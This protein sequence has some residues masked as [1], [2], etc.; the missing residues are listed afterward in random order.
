MAYDVPLYKAL[1]RY[2]QRKRVCFHMPG[3][4]RGNGIP[5][6]FKKDILSMDLTELNDTDN[7]HKP[8]GPI[9]KAQHL[10]AKAFGAEK[11]FFLVNGATCGIEA[12]ITA[13]CDPG[14][15]LIIDR[16]CH[17][18]VISALILTGVIPKYI[19]PEYIEELGICGGIHLKELERMLV[20]NPKAKGVLI[21]S[22]NYYGLCSDIKAIAE[23]V[24]LHNKLLLVDEAHGTH[25]YFSSR[26]P[27]GAL[28]SGADL[29]VHGAHKTLPALTQ[30]GF[31]HVKSE[32]VDIRR[33][34]NSLKLF[35]TSSPSFLLLAYLDISRGIMQRV[36][37]TKF[38][39]ILRLTDTIRDKING[40]KGLYCFGTDLKGKHGVCDIDLTR[41]VVN[42]KNAGITGYAASEMLRNDYN[43]EVEMS[44][45]SN[46]IC[47]ITVSDDENSLK[48]LSKALIKLNERINKIKGFTN[49]YKKAF[50]PI[51]SISPREAFFSKTNLQE[52]DNSVGKVCAE[53]VTVFPPGVP[54]LCPGEVISQEIVEYI[55]EIKKHKGTEH[56]GTVLLCRED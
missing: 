33:L 25:F 53:T 5:K 7:L 8:E 20:D 41:L 36:G 39:K 52:L 3:H 30:S 6:R 46:I 45:I 9:L 56:E 38:N 31:L 34:E 11:S 47:I 15:I 51:Y 10:A 18:S 32:R 24:H 17:G 43:I 35:Q 28:A 49:P 19:Y 42:F 50:K 29:C 16:N 13:V 48:K 2:V 21:T 23:L 55:K 54:I 14:D 40:C 4:K 22:P 12:M 26:L 1:R 27:Q 37:E 44:D